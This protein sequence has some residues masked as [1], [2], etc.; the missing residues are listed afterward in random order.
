MERRPPDAANLR[1]SKQTRSPVFHDKSA[2]LAPGGQ[3]AVDRVSIAITPTAA[4][5]TKRVHTNNSEVLGTQEVWPQAD[6]K[7]P[8]KLAKLPR[9]SLML[10]LASRSVSPRMTQRFDIPTYRY[11]Y[12]SSTFYETS[13]SLNVGR[14]PVQVTGD[15]DQRSGPLSGLVVV[16]M[17][18]IGPATFAGRM[19]AEMGASVTRIERLGCGATEVGHFT[20][21]WAILAALHDVNRGEK[22]QVADAAI[23][24]GAAHLLSGH[25][26]RW[27]RGSDEVGRGPTLR[28]AE[29]RVLGV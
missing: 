22:G 8:Q 28:T 23:L 26:P 2:S 11:V 12:C 17:A 20:S 25:T 16:Q 5:Q 7:T 29:T 3:R 18:G 1:S 19:L 15:A 6:L 24:D 21:P 4:A 9:S 27:Q 10:S 14:G 13:L